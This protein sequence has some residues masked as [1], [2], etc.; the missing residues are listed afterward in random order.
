[1]SEGSVFSALR[2]RNFRLFWTGQM[3]S[4]I[5]TWMQNVGQAWLVLTTTDSAFL[6]GLVS[7]AQF[8]PVLLV[9]LYA[10]VVID[11]VSKRNLLIFTQSSLALLALILAVLVSTKTVQYWHIL[12]LA[13]LLGVVNSFDMPVRQSYVVELVGGRE[14]LMNAIA[15]NSAIFNG[16]RIVGPGIAGLVMAEWGAGAAFYL[17]ALSFLA[18]IAG[19]LR[20]PKQPPAA[21]PEQRRVREHLKEGLAYI[22]RVR[23]VGGSLLLLGLLSTFAMNFN[24]LVPVYARSVLH[25][26]ARGYG[27]LLSSLGLGALVG[28][29]TLAGRSKRG[30]SVR[31]LLAAGLGLSLFQALLAWVHAYSL[32]VGVLILTGWSMMTFTASVNSTIQLTVPDALRGRVMSVYTLVLAGVTPFG[33]LFAGTISSRWGVPTALQAGGALGLFACLAAAVYYRSWRSRREMVTP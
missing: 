21:H 23:T 19:L 16:A 29:L 15:L 25:Q 2:H 32:A 3:V 9:S 26:S 17:N 24:V 28:A 20:I 27:F 6:L 11:R 22:A 18:V 14:D 13:L 33:S 12:T 4:L 31:L 1:M 7:A 30:P 5:G 8:L 10:G